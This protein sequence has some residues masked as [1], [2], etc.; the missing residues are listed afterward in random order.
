LRTVDGRDSRSG[1]SNLYEKS[2][3]EQAFAAAGFASV[4]FGRFPAAFRYL[5]LWGMIVEA[6]S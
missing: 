6:R 3:L 4:P 2:E 5:S 1:S